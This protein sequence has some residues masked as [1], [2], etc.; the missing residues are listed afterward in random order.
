MIYIIS[1][2]TGAGKNTVAEEMAK[3][4]DTAAIIDFDAVRSM[5]TKPHHTPW[6]GEP[7]KHQNDLTIDLICSIAKTMLEDGRTPIILDVVDNDS[8]KQ[9]HSKLEGEV[10]II[11]L[12]PSWEAINERNRIRAEAEG[13]IRLTPEQ[14]K[15]VFE[16]QQSFAHYDRLIDNSEQSPAETAQEILSKTQ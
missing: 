14:L 8:A 13:R 2:P 15:M 5:F 6:D 9:Y 3:L 11:Q 4:L 1:G 7:G 12:L 16:A 10:Q